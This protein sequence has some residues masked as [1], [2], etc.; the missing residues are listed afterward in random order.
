VPNVSAACARYLLNDKPHS[1]HLS[2]PV[3]SGVQVVSW[4]T[5][6]GPQ[7][8]ERTERHAPKC[9]KAKK[10]ASTSDP[11]IPRGPNRSPSAPSLHRLCR[12]LAP[13]VR[14]SSP[15]APPPPPVVTLVPVRRQGHP[16]EP[17]FVTRVP[18]KGVLEVP[19]GRDQPFEPPSPCPCLLAALRSCNAGSRVSRVT[20][21]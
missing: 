20:D 6:A 13:C 15:L 14:P 9:R 1:S 8:D 7:V 5:C 2:A 17:P 21:G 4:T 18:F 10:H 11:C 16:H 12:F 19:Q 3:C